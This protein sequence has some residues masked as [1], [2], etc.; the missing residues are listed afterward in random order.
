MTGTWLAA[1]AAIL[2]AHLGLLVTC[3]RRQAILGGVCAATGTTLVLFALASGI[4]GRPGE[5]AL[6]IAVAVLLIGIV[7]VGLGQAVQRL[8]DQEPEEGVL[9]GRTQD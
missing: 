5:D 6:I 2:A 4:T 7:L 9:D 8:L 3:W 1:G